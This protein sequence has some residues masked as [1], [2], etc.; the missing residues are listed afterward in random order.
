[1]RSLDSSHR[2][3]TARALFLVLLLA[4]SLSSWA[5]TG[6]VPR[7]SSG[8]PDL[9]GDYDAATLTPLLRPA[10]FG[11]RLELT[12]EEADAMAQ[13]MAAI[14]ASDL[15]PSDPEREAPPVGGTLSFHT[16]IARA[17][18]ETGTG[19][20]NGFFMDQG[21]RSVIKNERQK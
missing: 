12:E 3:G 16:D 9:S 20:Y 7:T 2:A 1:M 15:V 14:Y 6:D 17:I 13:R 5:Q 18:G 11:D 21:E 8:R 19:G 10:E 4:G